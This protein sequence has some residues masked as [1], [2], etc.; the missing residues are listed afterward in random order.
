[1]PVIGISGSNLNATAARYYGLPVTEGVLIEAVDEGSGA[2]Q[3][4]LVQGDIIV[5]ADGTAIT[6]MDELT[7]IKNTHKAGET[8]VLT[9]ARADGNVDVTVTL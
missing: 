4:G 6:N 8:M 2:D 5:A 7:A 1:V 3:A 9:L